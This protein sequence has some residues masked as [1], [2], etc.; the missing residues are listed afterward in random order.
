MIFAEKVFGVYSVYL[1][2]FDYSKIFS[3]FNSFIYQLNTYF[4]TPNREVNPIVLI[5]NNR[6]FLYVYLSFYY[7]SHHV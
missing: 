3:I 1:I 4:Y 7:Y 2:Q 6:I 5:I